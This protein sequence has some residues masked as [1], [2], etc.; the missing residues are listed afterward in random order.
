MRFVGVT[1]SSWQMK[2]GGEMIVTD[3]KLVVDGVTECVIHTPAPTHRNNFKTQNIYHTNSP[4]KC[5]NL[6]RLYIRYHLS[7]LSPFIYNVL[8][9]RRNICDFLCTY[10]QLDP[11]IKINSGSNWY[12]LS[13]VGMQR[14]EKQQP[15]SALFELARLIFIKKITVYFLNSFNFN[16]DH[17]ESKINL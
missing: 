15:W 12:P 6:L 14:S 17:V 10:I 2:G 8:H 11:P 13:P 3:C 5:W 4:V 1:G 16:S 9:R 7:F